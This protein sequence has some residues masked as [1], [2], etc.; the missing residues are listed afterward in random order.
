MIATNECVEIGNF[1]TMY[2][3]FIILVMAIVL[4]AAACSGDRSSVDS[5]N[6]PVLELLPESYTNLSFQNEV[7]ESANENIGAYD[8]LYN[9][10]GVAVG[11][12]NNDGL[13]DLFFTGNS[14][15]NRLY[16]NQGGLKFEDVTETSGINPKY[17]GTGAVMVDINED[18]LLDIYVCNSGPIWHSVSR[19]NELYINRGQGKFVNE[20]RQRGVDNA[21]NSTQAVFFDYDKDGDLDLYVMNHLS[22][23]NADIA[24]MMRD[25]QGLSREQFMLQCNAM[26]R[27]NGNGEFVDVTGQSG[28]LYPGYGLGVIASDIDRDGMLDLY[29]ANDFYV[30]DFYY[31]NSGN[32]GFKEQ[33][34]ARLG[35]NSYYSM[36]C[37]AADFN[38]DGWIDLGIVDMSPADYKRSKTLMAS[39]NVGLFDLITERLN[40]QRQY[41]LNVMQLNRG[42]GYFSEVGGLLN[43]AKTDWSWSA[44]FADIDNDGWK[45]FYVTNGYKRDTKDNDFRR[46]VR[47][48]AT[49]DDGTAKMDKYYELL[50]EVDQVPLPNYI[51]KND[52][53]LKFEDVSEAWGMTNPTFS[54]GAAYADLDND[55]DLD[56]VE[57]NLD[58]PA[59][60][61]RNNSVEKGL[62]NYLQIEL[63]ADTYAEK[64]NARITIK[65]NGQQQTA[66][67]TNVRGYQSSVQ[68]LSHF[69]LGDSDLVDE[70]QV[71]WLDGSSHRINDVKA[72]RRITI[73]KE[74]KS[75]FRTPPL[76]SNPVFTDMTSRLLPQGFKHTE[77]EFDDFMTEVLLPHR[78]ST[79]GPCVAV[80]DVNGDRL[81]DFYIGGA[82]E[83][84]GALF[85]QQPDGTFRSS[86]SAP[87]S[88]HVKSEDVG[89]AFIDYDSDGDLDLYVGSGGGGEFVG[90]EVFLQDRV[91]SNDG[92][93]NFRSVNVLP[94]MRSSSG[95]IQPSDFDGDGDI[96]LFVCGRT[97]PGKYPMPGSSY[98]LENRNGRFIDATEDLCRDL[99][100]VGM[101]TD[102]T[103]DD[104]NGDGLEDLIVVGEWMPISVFQNEGGSFTRM[105]ISNLDKSEGWWYT[106]KGAD[107][108]N[109]GDT[110]FVVGNVG[111]NNKFHPSKEKPLHVY[112]N[113][114][115]DNGS[116]DIVLSKKYQDYM[117]PVRGKEC[118]SQQMPFV[119]E[120]FE[121]YAE[122]ANAS[123]DDIY[124]S[125]KLSEALH[126]E[127]YGF[128][129]V[130]LENKGGF[131]FEIHE[132]PREAQMGPINSVVVEDFN[133]DGILDMYVGGSM[134]EAEVETPSYDGN[135]GLLMYGNGNSS[136]TAEGLATNAG[137]FLKGNVKSMAP[138]KISDRNIFAFIVGNN[139][140]PA[141]IVF[142]RQ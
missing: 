79:L 22:V 65:V 81:E 41:M 87:W 38:N 82:S 56:L 106:I 21:G 141:Q 58:S 39:M 4:F 75:S 34:K 117:V 63:D 88:A 51:F 124:T 12:L 53:G 69:G 66:E 46:S 77:N 45:D 111:E 72:N 8:Y 108:D 24:E 135:V 54:N 107:F 96:D 136:F 131:E 90:N 130:Y 49:N 5:E 2:R 120:K 123:L 57:N 89:A 118:S 114:Y 29:V 3:K 42:M 28:L 84:S 98:L 71:D 110:D 64:L 129:S 50:Q 128:S 35:H 1:A 7:Y 13:P 44:L 138:I 25:L 10:G 6:S 11:D 55:G 36:G 112:A 103:W 33:G 95:R 137:V 113:D 26:Y 40:F 133:R 101:V 119:S 109:D 122:F 100:S 37:D 31:V 121:S 68:L 126:Y 70:V 9:G 60:I 125:E 19:R 15:G 115:D 43:I 30:P 94:Q 48:T 139:D 67:Y 102:A 80:G 27:N 83:Q 14:V 85:I 62:G 18:G 76:Q 16:F 116:I 23:W 97:A 134:F 93:G 140:G 105:N 59:S 32:G 104:L 86:N 91:Y 52:G 73:K 17:W 132:L 47:E 78:Q 92:A 142:Q 127:A 99:A 74:T 20:A 61:Y